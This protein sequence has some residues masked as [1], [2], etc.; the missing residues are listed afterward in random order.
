MLNLNKSFREAGLSSKGNYNFLHIV[1]TDGSDNDSKTKMED[2]AAIFLILGQTIPQEHFKTV[3]I[4][5]DLDQDLKGKK[6]LEIISTLGNDNTELYN[7]GGSEIND[8]FQ[9]IQIR[10][11][12]VAQRQAIHV[13]G[14]SGDLMMNRV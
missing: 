10:T 12:I 4:G 14:N 1:L 9:R 11:G 6:D 5:V 3:F 2:L 13:R 7:V 8:I